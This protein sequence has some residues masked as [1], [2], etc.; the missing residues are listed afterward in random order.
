M[1]KLLQLFKT[2][3]QWALILSAGLYLQGCQ[4]S[5]KI[6]AVES[7]WKWPN[8]LQNLLRNFNWIN[9][10]KSI[11]T[12]YGVDPKYLIYAFIV[13]A[14]LTA[15][16]VSIPWLVFVIMRSR[17]IRKLKRII[18]TLVISIDGHNDT[19]A[20]KRHSKLLSKSDSS[21]RKSN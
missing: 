2:T 17:K 9:K 5:G 4:A 7:I 13:T 18:K 16:I 21:Y 14:I 6:Q 1:K 15:I 19:Q 20:V 8:F 3:I 11:T 10:S 12:I